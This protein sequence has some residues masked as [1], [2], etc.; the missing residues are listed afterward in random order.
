MHLTAFKI[1]RANQVGTAITGH[2]AAKASTGF[3]VPGDLKE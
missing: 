1:R 3:C 2:H